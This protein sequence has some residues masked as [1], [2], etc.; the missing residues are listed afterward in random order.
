MTEQEEGDPVQSFA[1]WF[2][3]RAL[4]RCRAPSMPISLEPRLSVF[5][6]YEKQS[7]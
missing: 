1:T 6:A 3:L 7:E 4:L 2:C 5:N